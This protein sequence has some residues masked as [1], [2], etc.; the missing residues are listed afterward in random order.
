MVYSNKF[1]M[2]VL[3]NGRPQKEKANGVVPLPFGCE[4]SLRFRNKNNRRAV[5]K[6]FIDGENVS[7]EGG[8]VVNANDYVDIK[9]HH[10]V[11]RSF[12][13][14]ELDSEDAIDYGKDGPNHDKTK[15]TIEAR[16]YLEKEKPQVI[17]R[18][19]HHDHHHHHHHDHYHPRPRPWP[20]PWPWY[21]NGPITTCGG[22]G[23]TSSLGPTTCGGNMQ[24]GTYSDDMQ[25]TYSDQMLGGAEVTCST[26]A[27]RSSKGKG[28]DIATFKR[29]SI[30]LER[31]IQP[32]EDLQDGCTVEGYSTGQRFHTVW[33]DTEETYTS[34]KL[35]LQ[36]YEEDE[37][38]EVVEEVRPKKRRTN[39]ESRIE[40]LESENEELRRQLAELENEKL[41]AELE[42]KKTPKKKRRV[43][44]KTP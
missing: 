5:V 16:F 26:N 13:F 18:D 6:I 36:G 44:K 38:E 24:A 28:D 27:K 43:R 23:T 19:I 29:I 14:V 3:L 1:V 10:D 31:K 2:C 25:G 4:Y 17:Y 35:F 33:C 21:G 34:L 20:N 40:D 15:G 37:V 39:K 9:R 11:D 30:P 7:G 8:Y 41:K 42:A 32:P 22:G 12:K